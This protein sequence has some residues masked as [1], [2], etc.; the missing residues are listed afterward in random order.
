MYRY[1]IIVLL[2]MLGGCQILD[3]PREVVIEINNHSPQDI[4]F[5]RLSN[6]QKEGITQAYSLLTGA[7][8]LV[9]FGFESMPNT[10]GSYMLQYRLASSIDTLTHQFGYYTNGYPVEKKIILKIYADSIRVDHLMK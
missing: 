8:I 6:H 1:G 4:D 7:T 10:D 3:A 9:P 2:A 5:L